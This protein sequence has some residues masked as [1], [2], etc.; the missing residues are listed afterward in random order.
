MHPI[1]RRHSFVVEASSCRLGPFDPQR[2]DPYAPAGAGA[3]PCLAFFEGATAVVA[4]EERPVR[5]RF[6]AGAE[7]GTGCGGCAGEHGRAV[8]GRA[9]RGSH[10][11]LLSSSLAAGQINVVP[12]LWQ[13][14]WV[15]CTLFLYSGA[16]EHLL[17]IVFEDEAS[18]AAVVACTAACHNVSR[19]A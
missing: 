5:A 16:L 19:H 9:V 14:Q 10:T 18:A 13:P 12:G 4:L 8:R 6:R 1:P 17:T 11:L 15:P 7:G 3:R 2:D